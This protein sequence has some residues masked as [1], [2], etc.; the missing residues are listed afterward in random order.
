MNTNNN[1]KNTLLFVSCV[2]GFLTPF[3]TSGVNIATLVIGLEFGVDAVRLS[4]IT[5]AT[6]LSMAIFLVP[7]GKAGDIWGHRNVLLC[8]IL[9]VLASSAVVPVAPNFYL[10]ILLRMFQGCGGALI[11]SSSMAL[12]SSTFA[13]EER[14]RAVGIYTATIYLG[15]SAGPFLGGMLMTL[16]GWRSI[17]AF[18]CALSIISGSIALKVLPAPARK[19]E[20]QPFDRKGSALYALSLILIMLGVEYL[21]APAGV[22]LL[23]LGAAVT[24][25]FIRFESR[26]KFPVMEVRLFASSR[27]FSFSCLAALINYGSVFAVSYLLSQYLQNVKELSPRDAGMILVIQ[28]ILQCLFSPLAGKASDHVEPRI[29]ATVGIALSAAGLLMLSALG[30]DTPM[31]FIVAASVLLG[32]GFALFSS[33]NSNAIMSSV[34]S[35]DYGVASGI[36]GAMRLLGQMGSMVIVTVIFSLFVGRVD[37]ASIPPELFVTNVGRCFSTLALLNMAGIGFSISRGRLRR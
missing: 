20:Y 35:R 15:L 24:V 34:E 28:P 26:V 18:V 33:P 17:F 29:L 12:I 22:A 8:G 36:L 9:L 1:Y 16:F 4:W 23:L 10:L 13:K 21:R 2:A 25:I 32:I 3:L 11:A 14:G 27:V 31:S 30:M 6:L 5:T 37:I 19:R 7:A